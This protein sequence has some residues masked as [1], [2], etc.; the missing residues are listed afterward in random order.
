[1]MRPWRRERDLRA[2]RQ[3][4]TGGFRVSLG[5]RTFVL[6][7]L[8]AFAGCGYTLASTGELTRLAADRGIAV[9]AVDN[10]SA[11]P[12]AGLIAARFAGRG[13]AARGVLGRSSSA[14]E[15]RIRV[16]ALDAQPAGSGGPDSSIGLP[17]RVPLWQANGSLSLQ[18]VDRSREPALVI[19]S[20][21]ARGG[22]EYRPGDDVEATEVS[23]SL[24]LHRLLESLVVRAL[25]G[26]SAR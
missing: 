2:E 11:E 7:G 16:D 13:L 26:L 6:V 14:L 9:G 21:S 15:L 17:Q 3:S 25:D 4:S 18:L 23:R 20:S 24:A 19:A 5:W 12:E 10:R 1:M 8:L 22:E